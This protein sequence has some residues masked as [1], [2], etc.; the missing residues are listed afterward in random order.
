MKT[1]LEHLAE[2]KRAQSRAIAERVPAE[3]DNDLH[4]AVQAFS[5]LA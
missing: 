3:Q 1:S 5:T 4:E 2:P